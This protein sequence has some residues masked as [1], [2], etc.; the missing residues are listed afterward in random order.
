[1][2][3][4]V[5]GGGGFLG[6]YIVESLINEGHTVTSIGRRCQKELSSIGVRVLRVDLTNYD[7][8]SHACNEQDAVMHVAAKAGIW[9]SRRAY[10]DVNVRGTR[11]IINA[12]REKGIKYL[13]YTSTPSVVFNREAFKGANENLPYGKKWLCNYAETKAIAEKEVLSAHSS[14]LKVCALRP[15]LIFGPRDPHL[16]PRVISA[17]RS[18][19]LK[20]IGSGKN[21]VD[22]TYVK[23]AASAHIRALDALINGDA[24]GNAYF[25]SQ[26]SPVYLWDWINHIL[27]RL[28][29]PSI[30]QRIPLSV[31][32]GIGYIFECLWKTFFLKG[33]PPITR[34]TAIELAKDH[35]FDIKKAEEELGYKPHYSMEYAIDETISDLKSRL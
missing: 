20:I 34:F 21:K 15:H 22:L 11:N 16:L 19:R 23:D 12:C 1:M 26:G 5:T 33:E 35:Y 30:K 4:L 10:Y 6:R 25:I 17:V 18:K 9:G 32:Y 28:N 3:I 14:N 29:M 27:S 24:G 2:R 13:V 8:V 7:M 31:A